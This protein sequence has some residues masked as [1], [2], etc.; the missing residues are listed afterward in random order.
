MDSKMVF[1]ALSVEKINWDSI[2]DGEL[3]GEARYG[4]DTAPADLNVI[5]DGSS[6]RFEPTTELGSLFCE[7]YG[8]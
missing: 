6:Y 2:V 8:L 3:F 1:K 4:N 7:I 5:R